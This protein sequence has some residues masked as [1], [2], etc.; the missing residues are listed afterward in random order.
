MPRRVYVIAPDDTV[1]ADVRAA[2]AAAQ[3]PEIA[4]GIPPMLAPYAQPGVFPQV[5]EVPEPPPYVPP[6]SQTQLEQIRAK[7]RDV[8]SGQSTFTN[9][10]L[11][12]LVAALVLRELRDDD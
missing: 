9:A 12:K 6:P 10:Q 11:Q 1:T 2:A 8:F 3:C 4:Q 7:A 5:V